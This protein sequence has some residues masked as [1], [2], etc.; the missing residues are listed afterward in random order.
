MKN[1]VDKRNMIGNFKNYAKFAIKQTT[2][3]LNIHY[4]IK[5]G[6]DNTTDEL[7]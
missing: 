3:N 4:A 6:S 1:E 2:P 7:I 5:T